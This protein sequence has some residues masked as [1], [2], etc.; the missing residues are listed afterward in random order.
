MKP[1]MNEHPTV[2]GG[3]CFP[4]RPETRC[5]ACTAHPPASRVERCEA[6]LAVLSQGLAQRWTLDVIAERVVDALD[7]LEPGHH[8]NKPG[9]DGMEGW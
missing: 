4:D 3:V 2:G 6:I 1:H 7:K 5:T 8:A 9:Y